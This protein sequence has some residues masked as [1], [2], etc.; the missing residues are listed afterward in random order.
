MLR[1]FIVILK[2]LKN[3]K[4]EDIILTDIRYSYKY[5]LNIIKGNL[6]HLR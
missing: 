1:V 2:F 6:I 4:F 3:E 5:A